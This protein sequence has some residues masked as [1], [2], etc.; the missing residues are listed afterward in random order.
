MID[1][2]LQTE[3]TLDGFSINILSVEA[4]LQSH[5]DRIWEEALANPKGDRFTNAHHAEVI[6]V[7]E[8][9]LAD[10]GYKTTKPLTKDD[11]S[12]DIV[13]LHIEKVGA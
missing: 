10:D 7:I 3:Y 6:K 4:D 5:S 12:I 1:L 9:I 2:A 11:L 13:E 8:S